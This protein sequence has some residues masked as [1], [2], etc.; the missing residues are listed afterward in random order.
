MK[1]NRQNLEEKNKVNTLWL[2]EF[3]YDLEKNA[4]NIDYLKQYLDSKNKKVYSSIEEKLSDIRN[5]VGLDLAIKISQEM[6]NTKVASCTCNNNCKC[7]IKKASVHDSKDIS[8]MQNILDFIQQ[9]VVSEPHL[10]VSNV[11]MKC[12]MEDALGYNKLEE[13]IDRKKLINYIQ[14]LIKKHEVQ[15]TESIRYIPSS[16]FQNLDFENNVAEYY[17]HSEPKT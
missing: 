13:K 12:K 11:I 7:Q 6:E 17:K 9:V 4:Q 16:S 8:T 14:D 15:S 10:D 5:R 2:Y 1:I 3:A